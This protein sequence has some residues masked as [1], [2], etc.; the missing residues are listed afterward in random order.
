MSF[1]IIKSEKAEQKYK[2]WKVLGKPIPCV[3]SYLKVTGKAAFTDDIIRPN[4]LYGKILRSPFAHAKIVKIDASEAEALPG[5]SSVITYKDVETMGVSQK[6]PA[7]ILTDRVFYVGDVVAAVAAEDEAI[8]EEA[9]DL[10]KVEY[11]PLPFWL[12]PE[13]ASSAQPMHPEVTKDNIVVGM[14]PPYYRSVGDIKE[15][16]KGSDIIVDVEFRKPNIKHMFLENFTAV[17]EWRGDELHVWSHPQVGAVSFA[18]MLASIFNV[19]TNKVHVYQ[20]FIGGGFGGKMGDAPL[21]VAALAAMLAKKSG[22]PVKIRTNI[23]EHFVEGAVLDPGIST[24][25]YK[26]GADKLGNLKAIDATVWAG[27]GERSINLGIVYCGDTIFNTYRIPN[28]SFK[29][30]PYYTNTPM[31]QALRAY[32][33]QAGVPPLEEAVNEIAE[34]LGMDPVD[35]I[36]KNGLRDGD[37][38]T[39]YLHNDFQLAGGSLPELVQKAAEIFN[40]K[41]KWKGW[42]VPTEISGSKRRGIGL[43]VATHT[44]WGVPQP[45]RVKDTVII[46]VNVNDGT[47][48]WVTDGRDIGS[49]FDTVV[50]QVIAEVLGIDIKDIIHAP[51]QSV[52]QPIGGWT[53]ASKALQSTVFA[54]YNAAN[55]LKRNIITAAASILNVD[56]NRLVLDLKGTRIYVAGDPT[57]YV[58]LSKIGEIYGGILIGIG[59]CPSHYEGPESYMDPVTGRRLGM[60]GMFCSFAEVEVDIETG[61]IDVIKLMVAT[62]PGM[63][64]NPLMVYGQLIGSAVHGMGCMLW[65]GIIYDEKTGT[66]LNASFIEYPI[67][68]ALDVTEDQ[69]V[70]VTIVD[71]DD[72]KLTPYRAKG[73][74]EGMFA[75]MW[76]SIHMAVYNAIGRKIREFPLR[77]EKILRALGKAPFPQTKGVV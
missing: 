71:P 31:S 40:W 57:R 60:K 14:W 26:I 56:P 8:A 35:F 27:Q 23:R 76:H 17:A 43:A 33:S 64:L 18:M 58:K 4:M 10:I 28:R 68:T 16:F 9:L 77:P 3:N 20:C 63:I 59:S 66:P 72:A 52:G 48:E 54:A 36:I 21:R 15:G 39:Q 61:K 50:S 30:Y 65:E 42:S 67:P 32:G 70:C 29:A 44:A 73:I 12:T 53:F 19:P 34:K 51:P 74:A 41:E 47:V 46:K 11:E 55:N 2:E 75:A 37:I 69:F 25:K 5:V 49:G 7:Y 13:E 45:D 22:R 62:Q 24:F 6:P 1:K 38:V